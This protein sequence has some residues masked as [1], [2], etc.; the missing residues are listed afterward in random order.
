VE[1]DAEGFLFILGR[2]KRFAKISGEMVSLT[3][4]E[5]ALGEGL[6]H[7]GPKFA[8][9]VIHKPD[10]QRGEKLIAF[11]TDPKLQLD[12]IRSVLKERGFSNLAV[13]RELRTLHEMPMLGTGK[14]N[15]RELER[16]ANE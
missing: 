14:T 2:L 11:A 5:E 12:E 6:Q 8:V 4:V 13:P 16:L 7:Y 3:A 10:L 9:A 15:Y 1:V